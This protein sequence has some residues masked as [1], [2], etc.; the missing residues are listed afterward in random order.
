VTF[1]LA[2]H[3]LKQLRHRMQVVTTVTM[4]KVTREK[5]VGEK[6]NR[7]IYTNGCDNWYEIIKQQKVTER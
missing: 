2:A 1:Q 6:N 7:R 4:L 3:C 5:I